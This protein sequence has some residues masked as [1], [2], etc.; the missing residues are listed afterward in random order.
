MATALLAV[1][2]LAFIGL[3]LPDSL[4]GSAWPVMHTDLGVS[5]SVAGFASIVALCGTVLSSLVSERMI[6]RF[7]TGPVAAISI[8][9]TIIGIAGIS[10]TNSFY[11]LL[12]LSI[13]L[14]IGGGTV[15]SALNNFVA[16]NYEAKHMN[17]LHC[18]WGIG[19][20][21]GPLV[22]SA[23]LVSNNWRGAYRTIGLV[24]V[25]VVTVVIISLPLWKKVAKKRLER[26]DAVQGEQAKD[27]A[28]TPKRVLLKLP[29]AP[30]AIMAFAAYCAVEYSAGLWASTYFVNVKNVTPDVAASWAAMYYFGIMGGRL[31]SGFLAMKLSDRTLIR[32]G[33]AIAILGIIIIM[34][35]LGGLFPVAGLLLAGMGCAPIFPSMLDATPKLFGE[36]YSQGMMGVQL[37]GAYIGGALLSPM[38]GWVSP[39]IGLEAWPVYLLAI[40]AVMIFA[41]ERGYKLA[42]G[43]QMK[44]NN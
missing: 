10:F 3:G 33:Q 22:V 19:A 40:A 23:F 39:V 17:W 13:P 29:G 41:T 32:I 26:G 7:G 18:F 24:L 34:L 31:I 16:L 14:G 12:A 30:F 27:L 11:V 44:E 6:K 28:P 38:F 1:I 20:T 42:L 21:G 36:K 37:A 2:Y 8:C 35:P 43:A 5:V 4:L 9:L 15:D 25:G